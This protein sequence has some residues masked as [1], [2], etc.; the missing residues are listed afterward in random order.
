MVGRHSARPAHPALAH[1]HVTDRG[2]AAAARAPVVSRKPPIASFAATQQP[3]RFRSNADINFRAPD[4][5]AY[6]YAV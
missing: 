3:R 6:E 2:G 1:R 4:H 5:R